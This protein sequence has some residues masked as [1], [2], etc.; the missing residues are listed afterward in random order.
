MIIEYFFS[1]SRSFDLWFSCFSKSN[2]N[3]TKI[4]NKLFLLSPWFNISSEMW[5]LNLLRESYRPQIT[6]IQLRCRCLNYQEHFP[7][8]NFILWKVSEESPDRVH[9]EK[10]VFLAIYDLP[11][12]WLFS[13][14]SFTRCVILISIFCMV[15]ASW[16][17]MIYFCME[18]VS[19]TTYYFVGVEF[20]FF[21]C[22][23]CNLETICPW[24]L[25]LKSVSSSQF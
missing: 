4:F 3:L 8:S 9:E 7:H 18:H 5:F 21:W 14:I 20:W 22:Y 17:L 25:F 23:S 16:R 11:Y 15:F 10:S 19:F 12:L 2:F 6:E 13:F 24:L 1:L